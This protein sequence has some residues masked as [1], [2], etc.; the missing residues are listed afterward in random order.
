MVL[1]P[2]NPFSVCVFNPQVY[3]PKL[4]YLSGEKALAAEKIEKLTIPVLQNE[5]FPLGAVERSV[6]LQAIDL[7][8]PEKVFYY[9]EQIVKNSISMT[10]FES[11][12]ADPWTY[13]NLIKEPRFVE[14]VRKD[15][16]FVEFLETFGFL[17]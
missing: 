4:D 6:L 16:R 12:C 15:G 1:K 7:I 5:S 14:E 13:P 3:L 11:I 2:I 9:Y 17:G 8:M 10:S